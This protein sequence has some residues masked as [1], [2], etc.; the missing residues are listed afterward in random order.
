[1]LLE[2]H[3][4]SYKHSDG[5]IEKDSSGLVQCD[6]ESGVGDFHLLRVHDLHLLEPGDEA[7]VFLAG[8][9]VNH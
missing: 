2:T 9:L 3:R 1:M 4:G 7:I 8:S 5:E 6:A